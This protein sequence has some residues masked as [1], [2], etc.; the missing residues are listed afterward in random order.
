METISTISLLSVYVHK[1]DE[2][3]VYFLND[4]TAKCRLNRELVDRWIFCLWK[5]LCQIG[6]ITIAAR[7]QTNNIQLLSEL[8]HKLFVGYHHILVVAVLDY[9]TLYVYSMPI[10]ADS[11]DPSFRILFYGLEIRYKID[12]HVH[13]STI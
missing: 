11:I 7:L 3:V 12:G 1:W 4:I 13:R 9:Y 6:K 8:L 2:F 10:C 5:C